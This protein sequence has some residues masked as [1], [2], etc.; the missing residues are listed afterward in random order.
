MFNGS[1]FFNLARKWSQSDNDTI[2]HAHFT[3]LQSVMDHYFGCITGDCNRRLLEINGLYSDADISFVLD[4][5]GY[6]N[7]SILR[8]EDIGKI[9]V[10]LRN[11]L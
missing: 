10:I 9:M 1:Q 6:A 11:N 5:L 2:Y 4:S 7:Y 3:I 8:F